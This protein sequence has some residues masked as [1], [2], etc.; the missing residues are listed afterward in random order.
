MCLDLTGKEANHMLTSVST[1]RKM[2]IQRGVISFLQL[3]QDLPEKDMLTLATG[4][5]SHYGRKYATFNVTN[6]DSNMYVLGLRDLLTKSGKH[7]LDAFKD[8][9]FD[10][11]KV[12]YKEGIGDGFSR[13]LLSCEKYNV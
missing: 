3:A 9:L 8:I 2:N 4:E 5:A 6:A 12:Y 1:I 10:I 7:T 13:H 11:D